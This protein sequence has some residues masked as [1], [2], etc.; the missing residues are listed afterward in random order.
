VTEPSKSEQPLVEYLKKIPEI[1]GLEIPPKVFQDMEAEITAYEDEQSLTVRFPVKERYQNPIGQMQGGMIVAAIDNVFG[2]LSYMV[3]PPSVTMQMNTSFIN[4][5]TQDDSYI[6][7]KAQVDE[8][9]RRF[10]FMSARATNPN[11]EV[12]AL[13]QASFMRL[14]GAR[15]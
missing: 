15:G 3:S 11:G 12:I 14:R 8:M 5:V 9:T 4:A 7:V 6:E 2:P 1:K 13:S 10:L